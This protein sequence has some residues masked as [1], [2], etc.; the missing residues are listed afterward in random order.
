MEKGMNEEPDKGLDKELVSVV[1]PIYNVSLYVADCIESIIAQT[2]RNLEIILVDDGS[3]DRSGDICDKYAALDDRI[4]VLHKKNGGLVTARK[5]GAEMA[6]GKYLINV[7]GDDYIDAEMIEKLLDR[8][9]VTD[10][11]FVQCGYLEEGGG[12]R[13]VCFPDFTKD[14]K[15]SDKVR[16][17][18]CWMEKQAEIGNQI[19]TKLFKTPF[20]K[21]CYFEVPDNMNMGEDCVSFMYCLKYSDRVSGMGEA[22][23]HYR[24]R[25]DSMSHAWNGITLF[26]RENILTEYIVE[27]CE[28]FFPTLPQETVNAWVL[29]RSAAMLNNAIAGKGGYLIKNVF[30]NPQEL[31]HKRI[32]IYGAGSVGKDYVMQLG[33]YSAISIVAW[34]DKNY[35]RY[36]YDFREVEPVSSLKVKEFDMLVIA[37]RS[38]AVAIEIR[39]ELLEMGVDESSIVFKNKPCF[40]L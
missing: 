40:G 9:L 26:R 24:V 18:K 16:L 38:E 8:M 3:T 15:D 36:H 27:K 7:D 20:F 13:R 29:N 17:V 11:D 19:W 39:S 1:V 32:V 28:E 4:R 25:G 33:Q 21:R 31:K 34:V 35:E 12:C 2:Y 23:Y 10:S 22:L 14:L 37:V 30:S 6:S 5:A